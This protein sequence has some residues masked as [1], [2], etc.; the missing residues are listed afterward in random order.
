M[1]CYS[2]PRHKLSSAVK[3]F[4]FIEFSSSEE[5]EKAVQ[6]SNTF[7]FYM[8]LS[9]N[10][11]AL[12]PPSLPLSVS[13]F[14]SLSLSLCLCLSLCLS[15][16]LSVC[17]SISVSLY[18]SLS[19]CLSLCLCLCLSLSVS[20]SLFIQYFK[21]LDSTTKLSTDTENPPQCMP[22][23][24]DSELPTPMEDNVF[25]E[26]K[27]TSGTSPV[28]NIE[29]TSETSPANEK[30]N[31]DTPAVR[32]TSAPVDHDVT[33]QPVTLKR[34]REEDETSDLQTEEQKDIPPEPKRLKENDDGTQQKYPISQ[35]LI[36]PADEIQ[37]HAKDTLQQSQSSDNEKRRITA[38]RTRW[39]SEG[40]TEEPEESSSNLPR[41]DSTWS[42]VSTDGCI[43]M[44]IC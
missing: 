2:L 25:L 6:V 13:V 18:L 23:E 36:S 38:K 19:L 41:L 4:A 42:E 27:K 26:S 17:L 1:F 12:S 21:S 43:Y 11:S 5:A 35:D 9:I 24:K 32:I 8:C 22:M 29:K 15:L 10:T 34:P 30:S 14:L 33:T 3:G 39:D 20:L 44:Y 7:C 37:E 28:L 40:Q 31:T 16:S